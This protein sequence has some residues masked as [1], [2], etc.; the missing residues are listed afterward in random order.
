MSDIAVCNYYEG[1]E[2]KNINHSNK[3]LQGIK[4]EFCT[5]SNLHLVNFTSLKAVFVILAKLRL[6]F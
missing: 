6:Q 2:F 4:F 1:E 5:F 3:R